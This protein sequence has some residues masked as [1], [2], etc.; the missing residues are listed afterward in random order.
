MFERNTYFSTPFSC[1]HFWQQIGSI[2]NPRIMKSMLNTNV[3]QFIFGE[4][5]NDD[6]YWQVFR[7][8]CN[9]EKAYSLLY[10]KESNAF[11]CFA[12]LLERQEIINVLKQVCCV[13]FF[14]F[15]VCFGAVM[16]WSSM[17]TQ[18]IQYRITRQRKL[19]HF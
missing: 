5:R 19:Y 12:L 3:K 13:S 18:N 15:C 17:P 6:V 10:P 14:C 7:D 11:R 9:N 4:L 8:V 1:Q 2:C 16:F